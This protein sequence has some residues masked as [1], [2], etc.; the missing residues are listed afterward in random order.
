[1]TPRVWPY[2]IKLYVALKFGKWLSDFASDMIR[3]IDVSKEIIVSV[4][5]FMKSHSIKDPLLEFDAL[6]SYDW[7]EID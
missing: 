4:F 5:N 6:S 2:N 3:K 1:M 7:N